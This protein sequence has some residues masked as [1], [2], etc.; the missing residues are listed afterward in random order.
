MRLSAVLRIVAIVFTLLATW[1]FAHTYFKGTGK[2]ISLRGFLGSS[3]K[4]TEKHPRNKCDNSKKC[5][6]DFFAFQISSGAA[7][8]VGPSICFE[9]KVLMSGVKN[10]IG[11]GL[12]I[13]LVDG[14]TG[15]LKKYQYFDMFSGDINTLLKFL[16][17][18]PKSTLVLVASFDDPG[19]KLNPEARKLLTELGSTHAQNIGFRD[20]WVFL[21]AK[22]IKDKSPFEEYLK[23]KP[24]QNKY[25]GWPEA[26]KIEGCVPR[27]VA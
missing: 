11:R 1:L 15:I 14:V 3:S 16:K 17:E 4:T 9:D 21:G 22:D 10:N 12:N 5:P 25:D 18:I 2:T 13:A 7:N 19:T 20:S 8:V 23:N 24:D 6:K 27:K 26:L